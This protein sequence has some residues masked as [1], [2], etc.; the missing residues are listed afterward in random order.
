MAAEKS[1]ALSNPP[2]FDGSWP[3][4]IDVRD[5]PG[6]A[7]SSALETA[8]L[9]VDEGTLLSIRSARPERRTGGR[10]F[11]AKDAGTLPDIPVIVLING[12]SASASEIV[13]GALQDHK[14]AILMGTKSFGK[15]SVQ[16]IMQ[17]GGGNQLKLTTARYYTP[18]GNSIQAKGI[19]PDVDVPQARLEL[20]E[21]SQRSE[22]DLR[23]R[24]DND[25]DANSSEGDT[26]AE[27]EQ[28][29]DYQLQ[30]ALDAIHTITIARASLK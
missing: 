5:N 26:V 23:N 14:R 24:L 29:T 30:R 16:S 19:V 21:T 6:G 27:A 18:S 9:F 12:G 15:G 25:T 4:I 2:T 11:T 22:A 1:C 20:L 3:V 13:A 8:D 28:Q 7:L 10:E 17:L